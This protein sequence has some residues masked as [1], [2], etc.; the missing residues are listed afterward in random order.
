VINPAPNQNRHK[1]TEDG[2]EICGNTMPGIRYYK[3][4]N[5]K[6][7]PRPLRGRGIAEG[8]GISTPQLDTFHPTFRREER[9]RYENHAWSS[10][11]IDVGSDLSEESKPL[12]PEARNPGKF[13]CWISRIIGSSC[14]T[15]SRVWK[16]L[17]VGEGLN[18]R[19]GHY[20]VCQ[21]ILPDNAVVEYSAKGKDE[22]SY[23]PSCCE[24]GQ[25]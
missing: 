20:G 25:I 3:D 13:T 16:T 7:C 12:F 19:C 14:W 18:L 4:L 5:R 15:E 9:R 22:W 17:T 8:D 1:P 24:Q 23:K 21:S 6:S 2:S 10:F 11:N